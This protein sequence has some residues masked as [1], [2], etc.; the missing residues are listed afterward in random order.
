[1]NAQK[2]T[3][4]KLPSDR[5]HTLKMDLEKRQRVANLLQIRAL[6]KKG[7]FPAA[8]ALA[9]QM[10]QDDKEK[11]EQLLKDAKDLNEQIEGNLK[12]EEE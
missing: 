10:A 11:S 7:D 8:G 4:G 6:L 5:P 1:M 9:R 12:K 2:K 3:R